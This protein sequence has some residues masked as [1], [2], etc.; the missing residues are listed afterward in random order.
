MIAIGEGKVAVDM[1]RKVVDAARRREPQEPQEL[2]GILTLYANT[3]EATDALAEAEFIWTEALEVVSSASLDTLKTADVFLRYG[4]LLT[5]M[6]NYDGA[7]A[8]LKDAIHRA[9][10]LADVEELDRQILLARAWRGRAQALE[11]LGEFEQASNALDAL[12]N[13]K[14]KIRFLVFATSRG[15]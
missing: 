13:I 3:L 12:M 9:D 1:I 2:L 10:A 7:V 11:A 14:R 5:K 8:K 15:G 6:H 4:L